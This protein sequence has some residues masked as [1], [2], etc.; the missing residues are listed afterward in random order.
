MMD[1]KTLS[2]LFNYSTNTYSKNKFTSFIKGDNYT[3]SEFGIKTEEI[4]KLLIKNNIK[5]GDKVGI[6][7]QNMPNW[8]VAFMSSS[9]FGRV[10]VPMLPDFSETEI[11]NIIEHSEAKAIFVSKKLYHKLTEDTL[12]KLDLVIEIDSFSVLKGETILEAER[13]EVDALHQNAHLTPEEMDLATII[14]TSGTTGNSKGVMLSHKN[15]ISHLYSSMKMRPSFEWD[16][17]LSIL[18]LSHT[19]E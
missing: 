14:Y 11:T 8:G 19:L 18:P 12:N 7:S 5:F 10:A 2:G 17:W 9:A 16:V 4:S 1:Y 3:Y 13:Q 6:L 15:L